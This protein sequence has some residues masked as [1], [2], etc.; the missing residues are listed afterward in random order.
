MDESEEVDGA[1]IVSCGD[2]EE[3]FELVEAALDSVSRL[4]GGGIVR[5]GRSASWPPSSSSRAR[6]FEAFSIVGLQPDRAFHPKPFGLTLQL[7]QSMGADHT[8]C[9]CLRIRMVF[10]P[11]AR[12]K[13]YMEEL[14]F[15]KNFRYFH[16]RRPNKSESHCIYVAGSRAT[17]SN[18]GATFPRS[19]TEK[20]PI[21]SI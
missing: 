18:P 14:A 7:H 16:A 21:I 6:D 1:A 10:K 11:S 13:V 15:S 17:G 4:V 9:V 12:F 19:S 8:R 20:W 5:G 3:M 2:A